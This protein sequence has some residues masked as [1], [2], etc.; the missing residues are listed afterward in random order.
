MM[1]V[2]AHT[3]RREHGVA[4]DVVRPGSR[5]LSPDVG[6]QRWWTSE[7]RPVSIFTP[8]AFKRRVY[9]RVGK[10]GMVL[11]IITILALRDR[12]P[13]ALGVVLLVGL[14]LFL[15]AYADLVAVR[16]LPRVPGPGP[17]SRVPLPEVRPAARVTSQV[18]R[19]R[20]S[21][22]GGHSTHHG[23]D[24]VGADLGPTRQQPSNQS[25]ERLT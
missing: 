23:R 21:A 10:V 2:S 16:A 14:G 8:S 3:P 20:C 1:E 4:D 11:M 25:Q 5:S 15:V 7:G 19:M 6:Q 12:A 17:W 22:E 9:S 13:E 18:C 24:I